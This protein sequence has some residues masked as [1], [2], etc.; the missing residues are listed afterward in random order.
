M[1]NPEYKLLNL[2]GADATARVLEDMSGGMDVFYDRRWPT[3]DS[4]TAWLHAHADLLRGK[5]VFIPGA[6]VGMETIACAELA[7]HVI[8]N[9]MSSTALEL[10]GEQLELNGFTNY[11]LLPGAWDRVDMPAADL[12]VS[13]F[14]VYDKATLKAFRGLLERLT[15]PFLLSNGSIGAF[16]TFVNKLTRPHEIL[17]ETDD[18]TILMIRVMDS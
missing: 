13:S 18:Q 4:F 14:L 2:D 12:A 10:C 9:D 17:Q 15:M 3:T 6:G 7:D 1:A 8:L 5:T 11:T 16:S